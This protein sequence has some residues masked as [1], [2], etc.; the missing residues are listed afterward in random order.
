MLSLRLSDRG[1]DEDNEI[2]WRS[3]CQWHLSYSTH[4]LAAPDISQVPKDNIKATEQGMSL[5][6]SGFL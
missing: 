2:P 5:L 6:A 1:L 4:W 3:T